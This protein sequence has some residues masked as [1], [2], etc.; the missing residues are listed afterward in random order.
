MISLCIFLL[1]I[2]ILG[3]VAMR[4]EKD[5]RL[6]LLHLASILLMIVALAAFIIFGYVAVGGSDFSKVKV[7]DYNLTEFRGSWLKRRVADPQR[8]ATQSAPASAEGTLA[9]ISYAACTPRT[10]AAAPSLSSLDAACHQRRVH[11][12]M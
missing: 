9:K 7:R 4:H 6:K 12:H 11:S 1:V 2:L 10:A 8:W 3:C 5:D